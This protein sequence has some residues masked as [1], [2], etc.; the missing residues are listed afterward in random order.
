MF[1]LNMIFRSFSRQFKRRLLI[2]VT[3]CLSATVSVAMLGV[4]FDVGDKLNAELS[5]YGSNIIVQPKSDAVVSDLYGS[6]DSGTSSVTST[7]SGSSSDPTSFLKES[8]AK[9]IKTIFWAFNITNFAPELNIHADAGCSGTSQGSCKAANV[10]IVGTWF[11]KTLHMDSGESTVVGVDGMRSWW[12]VSGTWPKDG[13]EQAMAG[14]AVAAKLGLKIG[15]SVTLDKTIAASDGN[16]TE[17]NRVKVKIVGIFDSG[18]SDD[19]AIYMPS[20]MAQTLANLPDSVDKIEVKALTTP[21]NDLA[22]KAS[23]NPNALTQDEWETWYC[24]AYPSSIAY[25]IEE[26]LPGAVAKQVRQVAALQGDVLNKTQAVMVLMTVL[27]LVAAAI[28]V[29]NLMAASIGERGSEL[30]LLKAIGATD[31]AVSRLMLAETAVVALAGA[32][33]GALL[34]SGVAQIVGHVVFGSGITMRPMVFVLVF[35]LLAVTILVASLSS[36]RAILGL[37]PAEVLHGR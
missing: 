32:I 3:V 21:D 19:N 13:G 35:V 6:G 17:R 23:K 36:I 2:A 11:A 26:V 5:T 34:G 10:P 15:D 4:V 9:K 25:Q 20:I 8:D 29:A 12:K 22:R 33:V 1:F 7:A 24:T 31:G 37:K 27:S 28:A 14:S 16:G 18:D 30:A